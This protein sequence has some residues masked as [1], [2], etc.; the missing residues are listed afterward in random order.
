[1]YADLWVSTTWAVHRCFVIF[2]RN[3]L[4][5]YH[6]KPGVSSYR[7]WQGVLI[8]KSHIFLTFRLIC[9]ETKRILK[10]CYV[11]LKHSILYTLLVCYTASVKWLATRFA[12]AGI[13][14]I[15]AARTCKILHEV[16]TGSGDNSGSSPTHAA[17]Y[18]PGDDAAGAWS[19]LLPV[20]WCQDLRS[21]INIHA[22]LCGWCTVPL[23]RV[24]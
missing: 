7:S 24:Q 14:S 19:W 15:A 12:T 2:W 9:F 4:I 20:T 3:I 8:M 10:N 11:F 18:L 23:F 21:A 22:I 17:E 5:F 16:Q 13:R 1:M 6:M